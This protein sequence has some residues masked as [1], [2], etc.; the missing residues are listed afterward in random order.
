VP[1]RSAG[2]FGYDPLFW[3]PEAGETFAEMGAEAKNRWS[4]RG[5]AA[6]ALVASGT[7]AE[8]AT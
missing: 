8:L 6:R 4:H 1:P 7:L 2:G 5:A 3:V